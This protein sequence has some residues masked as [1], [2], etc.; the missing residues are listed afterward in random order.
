LTSPPGARPLDED[1]LG[2]N[3]PVRLAALR[4]V[5]VL[6]ALTWLVFPGFGG[7]DLSVS[8]A[9]D[10]PVVLEA[11][12]GVFTSVLVGGSFLAIAVRPHRSGP[13]LV[14][15]GVALATMLAAAGAALE[16][17]LLVYVAVLL[18]EAAA[19]IALLP[20]REPVRPLHLAPSR[21]LLALAVAGAVPWL[22]SALRMFQ[23]N[24]RDAG[25]LL[26]DVTNG[27]DHC[28]VQGALALALVVLPLLA[29]GWPR[30]RRH[31]G[32]GAGLCAAY[33]GLVSSAF[34][35]A[36][37]GF[38]PV[39]SPLC[40]AWGA[41]VVLVAAVPRL[42]RRQLRGEVVEPQGAL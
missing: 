38:G 28:S 3:P 4:V 30:G 37:A 33:L 12:W 1:R 27:V 35:D 40:L 42:Q 26:G 39:R 21:P 29:A 19:T 41:A 9:P 34:P 7:I 16:P 5:A 2:H 23:A 32:V 11:G 22:G 24:R 17:P 10:W 18:V 25:V 36:F 8:W 31:L 15:L 13:P 20:Q 14:V 6:S